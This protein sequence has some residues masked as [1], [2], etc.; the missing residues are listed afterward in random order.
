MIQ[1]NK[2]IFSNIHF[3]FFI[4]ISSCNTIHKEVYIC[5]GKYSKKY[6][7]KKN[8]NGLSNCST[9]IYKVTLSEAKEKG[10]TICAI[11]N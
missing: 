9:E 3:V 4:L 11:E 5:E 2:I 1:F 10:R 7:L 8:C 6:H